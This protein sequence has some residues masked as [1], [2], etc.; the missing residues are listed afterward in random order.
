LDEKNGE[1]WSTNEKVIG[2]DVNPPLVDNTHCAYAN[3]FEFGP[4][5]FATG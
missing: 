5:D 1:L 2:V 3:A 4:R